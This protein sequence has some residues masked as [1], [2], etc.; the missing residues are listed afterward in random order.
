MS[1]WIS[2]HRKIM[3]H[4][5]FQDSK[6]LKA[7]LIIL[8]EVNHH[9]EDV[10]I[11]EKVFK[12]KRGESV[13]SLDSWAYLFGMG[14]DKSATR[15]FFKL[16]ENESMIELKPTRKTTHLKVC[17]YEAYQNRRNV[18]ESQVKQFC[19]ES[20]TQLKLNNKGNNDKQSNNDKQKK[21]K[22]KFEE[23]LNHPYFNN[24]DFKDAFESFDEFR[25][26]GGK[27]K[28]WTFRA[29]NIALKI[30]FNEVILDAVKMLNNSLLNGWAGVYPLK[31]WEKN[32]GNRKQTKSEEVNSWF[33]DDPHEEILREAKQC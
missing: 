25:K 15:R 24:T 28:D 11:K 4:W 29:K 5:I 12:V 14:W 32:K 18:D 16:L 20:E 19:N 10:L 26:N 8:M 1:G 23:S 3:K 13:K 21:D 31:D 2:I 6:K 22:E 27:K 9:P 17:N 33:D 7:W 30:L